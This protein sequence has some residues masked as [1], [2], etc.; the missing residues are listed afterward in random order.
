V[1]LYSFPLDNNKNVDNAIEITVS[2]SVARLLHALFKAKRS[3]KISVLSEFSI[4]FLELIIIAASLI[5]N[6]LKFLLDWFLA[7]STDA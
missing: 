3:S 6:L 2:K 7:L 4:E 5:F 1:L